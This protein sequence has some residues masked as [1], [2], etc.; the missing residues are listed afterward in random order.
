MI[1]FP[2]PSLASTHFEPARARYAFPC[3]DEPA[4]KAKFKLTMKR[5]E[6]YHTVS[7]FNTPQISSQKEMDSNGETWSVD[8][9]NETV[10]M[11]SYLV[12]FVVSDFKNIDE[13]SQKGVVVQVYAK[14]QSIDNKEGQFGLE[15]AVT[16]IDYF[17]EYFEIDY[18]LNKSSTKC[19]LC[20]Y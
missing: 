11:S 1:F 3:F 8:V 7:L 9:F 16:V 17:S 19:L 10:P 2:N 20:F 14:P 4:F 18:P 13:T 15:E 6:K 12:A 5:D